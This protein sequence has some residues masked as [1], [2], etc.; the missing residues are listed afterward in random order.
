MKRQWIAA[1]PWW[2]LVT[3]VL[4]CAIL[5]LVWGRSESWI[6]VALAALAL[7]FA[8]LIA[9]H[10]AEVVANSVGEPFGTL[11]LALAVTIIEVVG[12]AVGAC[13]QRRVFAL[14]L[15]WLRAK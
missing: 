8:V 1:L 10:H 12:N 14:C 3:P 4:A 2:S 11:I 15:G 9:V 13:K 6:F 7:V 5:A